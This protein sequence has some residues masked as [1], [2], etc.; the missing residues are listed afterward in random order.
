MALGRKARGTVLAEINVTPLVD[1]MLVVLIIF[2][3][4]APLVKE[5]VDVELPNAAAE[6]LPKDEGKVIVSMNA[7][8]EVYVGEKKTTLEDVEQE[9]RE[10]PRAARDQEV[11]IHADT[12]LE[13]GKVV[14]LMAAVK[15]AGIT[16]MGLITHPLKE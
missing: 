9:V 6:P 4:T 7:R 3:V 1:V 12:S 2:M 5:G 13:Y 10:N 11:Y 16:R 15:R 14:K 8:G